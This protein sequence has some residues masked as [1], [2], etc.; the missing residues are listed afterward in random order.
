MSMTYGQLHV[1]G[2]RTY[3]V[4]PLNFVIPLIWRFRDYFVK[5][6]DF[7]GGEMKGLEILFKMNGY[8]PI[9]RQNS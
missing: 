4:N 3:T 9:L 5:T 2:I 8:L 1:Y 6:T 7:K